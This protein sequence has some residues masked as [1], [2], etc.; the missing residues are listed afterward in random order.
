MAAILPNNIACAPPFSD[1]SQLAGGRHHHCPS[2]TRG[3]LN[4]SPTPRKNKDAPGLP[5]RALSRIRPSVKRLDVIL[6]W[7]E[8]RRVDDLRSK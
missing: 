1:S 5:D 7:W 4:T 2:T 3:G 6:D 8:Q